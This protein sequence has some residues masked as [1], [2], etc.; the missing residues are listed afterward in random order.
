MSDAERSV[1][2]TSGGTYGPNSNWQIRT[3]KNFLDVVK[4][5]QL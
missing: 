2:E 5:H 4:D 3:P 1:T